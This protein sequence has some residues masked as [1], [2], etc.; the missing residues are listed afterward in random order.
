M[1]SFSY[2]AIDE[3]GQMMSGSI[4]ATNAVDLELRLRRL[5]LDLI[6][7]ESIKKSALMRASKVSRKELITFC[8]HLD[9]LMRAGVPII[10]A[11]ADLRDTVDN[12][13]FKQIIGTILEDIEG[14]LRLSDAMASHPQAFDQVFIA[15]I[16]TGEQAGQLPE[17]LSKLAENL[18]WQDELASQVQKAMMYPIFAGTVILGVV[19]MLMVFLVP[20]L[21]STMKTLTPNPPAATMALI[22]VSAVMSKYWY[23][24]LGA[25]ILA[26]VSLIVI[27]KTS[28]EAR[29]RIDSL[30]LN[31]PIMGPLTTKI[32]LARFSTYF[33]L[34]YQSGLSVL[35]CIH[36]S[37]K[38]VGNRVIEEGL[39]RIGREINEGT[40]ITQA[41]QNV[42]MFPPL[43]LRMLKVGESTG[44][45]DTS[46]LNVSYFY[47]REVKETMGKLQEM[48]QP[49][50]TVVLG[51]VMIGILVTIFL[52][53]YDVIS[54]IKF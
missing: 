3:A 45:L 2:R 27:A 35:D 18:K 34:M 4:D 38:I 50:L 54:K 13:G 8:F 41:F 42:R 51:G 11:L 49:I 31:L 9:Q 22:A 30:M 32:I 1:A 33:A 26:V 19:F 28:D 39:V 53:M 44:A 36:V 15:L 10:E 46:L 24:F 17:V 12:A 23:L 16:R 20:Q 47:N 40:G 21:G 52:P 14:G 5:G 37:E 48:I 25:P 43:V 7:F 29:Y 6:T